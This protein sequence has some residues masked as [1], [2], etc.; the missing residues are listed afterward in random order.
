MP[1]HYNILKRKYI[2]E[3][4]RANEISMPYINIVAME[5]SNIWNPQQALVVFNFLWRDKLIK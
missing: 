4:E 3:F 1:E 2:D 5:N